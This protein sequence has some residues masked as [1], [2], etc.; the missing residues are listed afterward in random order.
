MPS[1]LPGE[2][3]GLRAAA[4]RLRE[5]ARTAHDAASQVVASG[6]A[7]EG[8][9]RGQAAAAFA[10]AAEATRVRIEALARLTDAAAVLETYAGELEAAQKAYAAGF[11]AWSESRY[12]APSYQQATLDM[13]AAQRAALAANARA[14]A[15]IE[16]LGSSAADAFAV[17]QALRWG[18]SATVGNG[19]I[20]LGANKEMIADLAR[21]RF[22]P[23]TAAAAS[24]ASSTLGKIGNA[25]APAGS[26]TGQAL[27]DADNP[28]YSTAERI[29]RAGAAGA[30]VGGGAIAG[31]MAGAAAGTLVLPGPGSVV[32]AVGGFV[33][34]AAGGWAGSEVA[35][36]VDDDIVDGTG[37]VADDLFGG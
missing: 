31:A 35:D 30:T 5:A 27:R 11:R 37:E 8:R 36:S 14:A 33:L 26:A 2:P 9:W 16:R 28:Y 15:E 24:G 7:A 17:E 18:A 3:A 25:L 1:A 22:E 23:G 34:A 29:G 12:P 10:S 4:G 32:G 13:T 6:A 21:S 20:A 19:L